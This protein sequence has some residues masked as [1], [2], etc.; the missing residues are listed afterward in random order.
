VAVGAGVQ[1]VHHDVAFRLG[2]VANPPVDE[3]KQRG[4]ER[5]NNALA[6]FGRHE[7]NIAIEDL[8]VDR[9]RGG[10]ESDAALGYAAAGGVESGDGDL[11]RMLEGVLFDEGPGVGVGLPGVR[12]G[13]FRGECGQLVGGGDAARV[14]LANF[15]SLAQGAKVE[16]LGAIG[17]GNID[18][19]GRS[20]VVAIAPDEDGRD[21]LRRKDGTVLGIIDGDGGGGGAGQERLCGGE[22]LNRPGS[23]QNRG[24]AKAKEIPGDRGHKQE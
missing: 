2:D 18:A 19:P 21:D 1:V 20:S 11:G 6:A 24:C 10:G 7:R 9:V 8:P 14:D 3:V 23:G 12:G 13:L 22:R 16:G 4:G 5:L 15:H 17:K